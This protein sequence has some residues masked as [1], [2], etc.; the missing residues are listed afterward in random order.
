MLKKPLSIFLK[1]GRD[2]LDSKRNMIQSNPTNAHSMSKLIS[3][4]TA[5]FYL[6]LG[7]LKL[8]YIELFKALSKQPLSVEIPQ[9]IIIPVYWLKQQKRSPFPP[10]LI[11]NI[12]WDLI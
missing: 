2:F 3:K 6:K 7:R 5:L 8:S 1:N 11:W 10:R 12:P 9:A 4:I